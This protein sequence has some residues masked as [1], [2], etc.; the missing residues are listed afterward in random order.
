MRT[1]ISLND[2]VNRS[3]LSVSFRG[4]NSQRVE[5]MYITAMKDALATSS[6][7]VDNVLQSADMFIPSGAHRLRVLAAKTLLERAKD[8]LNETS[9]FIRFKVEEGTLIDRL[10]RAILRP[11]K[12][13]DALEP[14]IKGLV[15]V[16]MVMARCGMK[17]ILQEYEK[18][19]RKGMFTNNDQFTQ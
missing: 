9:P 14:S 2:T 4:F 17:E 1:E 5:E 13:A 18:Q 3:T 19:Y 10:R 6:T 11:P 15:D 8:H 16:I 12:T 7:E